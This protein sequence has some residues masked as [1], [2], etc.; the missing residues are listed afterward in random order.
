MSYFEEFVSNTTASSANQFFFLAEPKDVHTCRVFY[1]V[2]VGGSFPYSLLFGNTLDS[3]Y[4][5]GKT[6]NANMECLPWRIHSLKVAPCHG[7]TEEDLPFVTLAENVEI[8][9]EQVYSTPPVAPSV[10]RQIPA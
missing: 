9:P 6:G 1:R 4:G 3:T 2:T 5:D 10:N 8:T 7:V